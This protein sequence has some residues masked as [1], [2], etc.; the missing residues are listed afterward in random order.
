[1]VRASAKNYANVAVVVS[2][3]RYAEV[4]N[5]V[6]GGG[7]TLAHRAGLAAEAFSHTASYDTAVATWM[8]REVVETG[9]D[10]PHWVGASWSRRDV[11]RDSPQGLAGLNDD[12]RGLH[13]GRLVARIGHLTGT[14]D[15]R[16]QRRE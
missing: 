9:E 16:Q 6:E 15:H 11:L 8:A 14:D 4:I 7:F 3:A 1:M 5:A 2:P 13:R 10:F 12:A